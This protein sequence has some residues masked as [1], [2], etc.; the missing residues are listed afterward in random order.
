MIFK[1]ITTKKV[2]VKSEP[3]EDKKY[4]IGELEQDVEVEINLKDFGYYFIKYNGS[5][6]YV[7]ADGIK[8]I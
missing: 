8:E 2:E 5:S 7:K 1:G 3:L 4:I 6:A